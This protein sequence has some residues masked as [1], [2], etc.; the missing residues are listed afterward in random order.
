MVLVSSRLVY[1]NSNNSVPTIRDTVH[2][3]KE[4]R[5]GDGKARGQERAREGRKESKH[6]LDTVCACI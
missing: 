1:Q 4:S 3:L 2:H 6:D 5:V